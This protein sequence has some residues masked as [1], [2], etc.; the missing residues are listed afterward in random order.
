MEFVAGGHRRASGEDAWLKFL[1]SNPEVARELGALVEKVS[2]DL[3]LAY[4]GETRETT[5][6]NADWAEAGYEKVVEM[7]ELM[8]LKGL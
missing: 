5:F 3:R 7:N 4:P 8:G 6:T 2:A 1:R